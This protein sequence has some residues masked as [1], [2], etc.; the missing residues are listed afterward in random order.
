MS[1]T[2]LLFKSKSCVV[3]SQVE[4]LFK[5]VVELYRDKIKSET[6]DITENIQ[7]AIDN[8]VMTVPTVIFFKD[9]KEVK[10]FSGVISKEKLEQAIK[11]L[12]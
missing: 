9:E 4:P 10:R 11:E 8:G 7:A 1:L 3:C 5:S 6:V 12:G 2:I